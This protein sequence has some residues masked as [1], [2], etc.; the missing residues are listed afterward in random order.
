MA[1]TNFDVKD[2]VGELRHPVLVVGGT[3]DQMT[4]LRFSQFLAD[5]IPGAQLRII[6]NAGHMVILEQPLAVAAV[7]GDFLRAIVYNP[8]EE[9]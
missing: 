5:T 1:C 2:Q 3:K 8:G 9:S 4:P 7:L 6:P